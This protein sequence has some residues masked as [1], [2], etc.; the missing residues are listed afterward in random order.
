MKTRMSVKYNWLF[1]CIIISKK[2]IALAFLLP[3]N[4]TVLKTVSRLD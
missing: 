4:V 3:I 1:E 2:K